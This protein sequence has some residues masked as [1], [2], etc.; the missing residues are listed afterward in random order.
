MIERLSFGYVTDTAATLKSWVPKLRKLVE[1]LVALENDII[2]ETEVRTNQVFLGRPVYRKLIDL[3]NLPNATSK[4]VPHGVSNLIRVVSIQGA[5]DNGT[6][7]I[8]LPYVTTVA[9]NNLALY[10]NDT[11][12]TLD[13]GFNFSA[14]TGYLEMRYIRD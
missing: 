1:R 13:T 14:Y 6:F 2:L 9:A 4:T 8:P 5:A 3:G 11:E 12:F 7:Q 10:C